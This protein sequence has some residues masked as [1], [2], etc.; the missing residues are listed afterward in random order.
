MYS[1]TIRYRRFYYLVKFLKIKCKKFNSSYQLNSNEQNR[2]KQTTEIDPKFTDPEY[3][4]NQ[5]AN[6]NKKTIKPAYVEKKFTTKRKTSNSFAEN[7]SKRKFIRS[8]RIKLVAN[9]KQ[10][11]LLTIRDSWLL[12]STNN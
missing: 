5:E 9:S 6:N 3:P 2:S 4:L 11:M 10:Q 12:N 1:E 7:R 8:K